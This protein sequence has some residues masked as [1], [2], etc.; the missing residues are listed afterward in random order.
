MNHSFSNKLYQSGIIP[1]EHIKYYSYI[2]SSL[3]S[4]LRYYTII[5]L[6]SIFL[7]RIKEALLYILVMSLKR[8]SGGSHAPNERLC[9]I[10][11]YS[12]VILTLILSELIHLPDSICIILLIVSIIIIPILSPVDHKNKRI[13]KHGRQICKMICIL[14]LLAITILYVYMEAQNLYVYKNIIIICFT[15]I[16]ID[17]ISGKLLDQK[18]KRNSKNEI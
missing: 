7:G 11:S 1:E 2:L 9:A 15:T 3:D 18:Q 14:L 6:A 16:F 12:H 13:D 8:F 5:I 4:T 10:I 17:Q